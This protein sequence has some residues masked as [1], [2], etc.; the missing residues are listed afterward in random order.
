MTKPSLA[1]NMI[2]KN[3]AARIERC[4]RSVLPYV[5]AVSI[6]DTGSTDETREIITRVCAEYCVPQFTHAGVFENFSQARNDAF[7][8]AQRNNGGCL[9]FCQFALLVDADMELVVTDPTAFDNLNAGALSY[10]MMQKGGAVSY[11]N[12]RLA[13]LQARDNPYVGV[14]HEYLD[15]PAAGLITGAS[16][17]DHADGANR[18]NKFERDAALLEAALDVEPTNARY[19]YYLG[20]TYRDWR[21]PA[22]A[23]EAYKKRI[24]LGGWDE[25]THSA[26]MNLAFTHRDRGDPDA[27]VRQ[28][29]DAYAFRPSRAE[30]LYDLAKY[31]REKGN[32][33]AALLFAT[34]G[35]NKKRPDDV[36]FVNDFVYSHGLRYEYAVAGFYDPATCARAAEITNELALDPACPAEHRASARS[37]LYWF[38]EPLKQLCPSLEP[39]RLNFVP[40]HGYEAMNPSVEVDQGTIMCN[41]RCVNYR[42][43]A[44]GAY[45]IHGG[46]E[47]IETRNFVAMLEPEWLTTHNVAEVLWHRPPPR[48]GLVLGLEDIRLWRYCGHLHFS[49]TVREQCNTGT[50]QIVTGSLAYDPSNTKY[51][52]VQPEWEPVTG[53][54][55][56]EK[57]WMP[58]PSRPSGPP[59]FMYR[60]NSTVELGRP[61]TVTRTDTPFYVDE[62]SGSSQLVPFKNGYLAVVHEAAAGPDG[63]RTYWHRFAW[64]TLQGELHRLSKPFVFFARQIEFCAGLALHPDGRRLLIS[65][66]VRDEE[67]WVA[68]VQIEE[69]AT[70]LRE[71]K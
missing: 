12:R 45:I 55:Q 68:T 67:A 56:H 41:I 3:E 17:I 9:P 15:L 34:A 43:D 57:N 2:V 69:V 28:M 36:L 70:L 16:F 27:F 5:K 54:E 46:G 29:V 21:R 64:F 42:I 71:Y 33:A 37:N 11:M 6:I 32:N 22:L 59:R 1:L 63:K 19:W 60:C 10:D 49:A 40:P 52:V 50:C 31:Y 26:M 8:F 35:I 24:E 14:T 53:E 4:L 58:M 18:V 48:F 47:A 62:I 38:T 23:A 61:S 66:G 20:N 25:E 39:V 65:F 44:R 30:P 7:A 13:N 51:M